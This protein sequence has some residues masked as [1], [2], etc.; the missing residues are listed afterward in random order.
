[1][2]PSPR[3]PDLSAHRERLSTDAFWAFAAGCW[4]QP[5]ARSWLLQWQDRHQIDVMFVLFACWLPD[6]LNAADWHLLA[7]GSGDWNRRVTRRLRALRR[8]IPETSWD[9]GHRACLGLEQAAERVEAAWLTRTAA[10]WRFAAPPPPTLEERLSRLF[11]GL[12]GP[13]I[14]QFLATLRR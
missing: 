3:P 11:P 10:P 8:R 13:E 5:Q 1:L 12:P 2:S 14:D 4:E 9:T 6:R 7:Q